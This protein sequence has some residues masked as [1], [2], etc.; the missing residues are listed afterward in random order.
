VIRGAT[1]ASIV[2]QLLPALATRDVVG[3]P[4][5]VP[6]GSVL[7][8]GVGIEP[9]VAGDGALAVE[10]RV[11]VEADGR[12]D[13]VWRTVLDPGARAADRGWTDARVP[14][15]AFA[16]RTVRFR[17]STAPADPKRSGT[18]L[19]VWADPA[20]LAPG[21]AYAESVVLSKRVG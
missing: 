17:F 6:P 20:V 3:K 1:G 4:I 18:S 12:D 14:L 10:F 7:A 15:D 16:G 2:A 21:P 8:F 9:L 11:A 19:P 5:T 13:V